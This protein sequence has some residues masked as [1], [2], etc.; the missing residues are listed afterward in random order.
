[1]NFRSKSSWITARNP[2]R[3]LLKIILEFC[4]K[5]LGFQLKIFVNKISEGNW[6]RFRK[7]SEQ[8]SGINLSKIPEAL[9]TRFQNEPEE[10]S[11][12][13]V[14]NIKEE[15]WICSITFW[16][17]IIKI[18]QSTSHRISIRFLLKYFCMF[19]WHPLIILIL[20]IYVCCY[21]KLFPIFVRMAFAFLFILESNLFRSS[22]H[23]YSFSIPCNFQFE[24]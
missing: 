7:K 1:M 24:F 21:M 5:P 2:L 14:N 9:S 3:F 16:I 19:Y 4:S 22:I 15:F 8:D 10:D 11:G 12:K 23:S 20:W 13:N 18:I 6:T 17:I